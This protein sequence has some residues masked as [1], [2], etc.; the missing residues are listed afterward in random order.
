[1]N[2]V[3][4]PRRVTF[5]DSTLPTSSQRSPPSSNRASSMDRQWN[6]N[7]RTNN[8]YRRP[9]YQ[10]N[11]GRTQWPSNNGDQRSSQ[12][13]DRQQGQPEGRYASG[14][15]NRP[16]Y[17]NY[18]CYTCGRRGHISRNCWENT[19]RDSPNTNYRR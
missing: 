8:G 3:E 4:P 12:R 2:P 15:G 10:Q 19:R 18:T 14:T 6:G 5:D 16:D 7:E 11:N 17:S 9:N 1:V 13:F